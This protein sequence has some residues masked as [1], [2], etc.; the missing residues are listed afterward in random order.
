MILPDTLQGALYPSIRQHIFTL[1]DDTFTSDNGVGVKPYID[2]TK[3]SMEGIV[4]PL[5]K[6]EDSAATASWSY[7]PLSQAKRPDVFVI[8]GTHESLTTTSA[9]FKTPIDNVRV[10]TESF[11]Y[12]KEHTKE[13]HE[14]FLETNYVQSQLPLL[15]YIFKHEYEKMKILP[16]LGPQHS[17]EIIS[18]LLED[19]LVEKDLTMTLV[20]PTNLT[21]YGS[22]YRFLPFTQNPL[23][24]IEDLD[25]KTLKDLQKRRFDSFRDRYHSLSHTL[26]NPTGLLVF[27][28]FCSTPTLECYTQVR[29]NEDDK[30]V[31]S[32]A[33]LTC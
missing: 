15:Q 6:Y 28:R 4:T 32:F 2:H 33:S 27:H 22:T 1:L 31:V 5:Y 8:I 12:F 11:R 14:P 19:L 10:H 24:Q 18:D 16:I 13:D 21:K 9:T 25:R 3:S 30:T 7:L 17:F 23:K 26:D 20:I 29:P